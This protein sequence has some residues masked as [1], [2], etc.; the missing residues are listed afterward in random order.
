MAPRTATVTFPLPTLT[1]E[2]SYAV[3][4]AIAN[5]CAK[6]P[7]TTVANHRNYYF[8]QLINS[9]IIIKGQ[10]IQVVQ[11]FQE[12]DAKKVVGFALSRLEA[13]SILDKVPT[14]ELEV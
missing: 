11:A 7:S 10:R 13:G 3:A 1:D 4:D 12:D 2:Q 8:R 9:D 14:L 6:L 5:T